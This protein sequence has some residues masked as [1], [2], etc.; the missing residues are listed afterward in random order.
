MNLLMLKVG[1]ED[2]GRAKGLSVAVLGVEVYI[3]KTRAGIWSIGYWIE[4][5]PRNSW[6]HTFWKRK[7]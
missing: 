2:Y 4:W 1:K 5:A 7:R 6:D 3:S